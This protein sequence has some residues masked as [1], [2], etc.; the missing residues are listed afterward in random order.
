M[1]GGKSFSVFLPFHCDKFG[2]VTF[3]SENAE[4]CFGKCQDFSSFYGNVSIILAVK[5]VFGRKK[6]E[7]NSL[8]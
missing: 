3:R 2:F 6:Y 4:K 7:E 1:K 8:F 5:V